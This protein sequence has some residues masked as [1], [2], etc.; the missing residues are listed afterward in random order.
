MD[1]K[2][3]RKYCKIDEDCLVGITKDPDRGRWDAPGCYNR[4]NGVVATEVLPFSCE[5]INHVCTEIIPTKV[6]ETKATCSITS[7]CKLPA[8]YMIRSDCRYDV[9]CINT[10]CIVVCPDW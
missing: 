5:C 2:D 10:K 7:E 6:S 3:I 9:E 8:E 4:E 1:L